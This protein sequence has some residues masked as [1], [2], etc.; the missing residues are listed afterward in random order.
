MMQ[1]VNCSSLPEYDAQSLAGASTPGRGII[2]HFHVV[3]YNLTGRG[4]VRLE[5]TDIP[6]DDIAS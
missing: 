2:V 5:S 1:R 3:K 4:I 6:E